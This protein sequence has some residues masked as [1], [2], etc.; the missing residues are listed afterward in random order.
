MTDLDRR[1]LLKGALGAMHSSADDAGWVGVQ[2]FEAA[3]LAV[4]IAAI[5]GRASEIEGN[6]HQAVEYFKRSMGML[7]PGEGKNDK[8]RDDM[9]ERSDRL[10][11]RVDEEANEARKQ[12]QRTMPDGTPV[13]PQ[14]PGHGSPPLGH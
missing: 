11:E 4:E 7:A 12:G 6:P 10:G 13:P 3:F 5:L 8:L 1:T 2:R 9:V 14:M